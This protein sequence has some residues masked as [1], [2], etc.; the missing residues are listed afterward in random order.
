MEVLYRVWK[1][2]GES[3]GRVAYEQCLSLPIEWVHE[4][5]ELLEMAAAYKARF[6]ISV[7]DAWIKND[8]GSTAKRRA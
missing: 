1:D 8:A 3:S 6:P 2:E 5:K 4:S 7:T